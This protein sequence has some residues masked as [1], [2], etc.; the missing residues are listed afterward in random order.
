SLCEVES[1]LMAEL[2]K[3]SLD[4]DTVKNITRFKWFKNIL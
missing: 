1:Q 3:L 4:F 2:N